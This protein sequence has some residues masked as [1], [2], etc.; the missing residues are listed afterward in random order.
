[1]QTLIGYSIWQPLFFNSELYELNSTTTVSTTLITESNQLQS[2]HI[3][4]FKS[5]TEI[6]FLIFFLNC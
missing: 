3:K 5:I 2:S 1:M 6:E 4:V